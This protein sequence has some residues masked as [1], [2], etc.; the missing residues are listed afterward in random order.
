MDLQHLKRSP[1]LLCALATPLLYAAVNLISIQLA[2]HPSGL[3]PNYEVPWNYVLLEELDEEI[4]SARWWTLKITLILAGEAALLAALHGQLKRGSSVSG[5]IGCAIGSIM[6]LLTLT[7]AIW[8]NPTTSFYELN[9][10]SAL[11]SMVPDWYFPALVTIAI[12]TFTA[13]TVWQS[14]AVWRLRRSGPM[15]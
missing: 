14:A 12:M 1:A 10:D 4:A 15:Q 3:H 5:L 13:L 8:I 9:D 6:Y 7:L 2:A 11:E